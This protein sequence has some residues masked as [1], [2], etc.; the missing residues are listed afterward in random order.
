MIWI[1][2]SAKNNSINRY[3]KEQ[4]TPTGPMY[5][6]ENF[7][8]HFPSESTDLADLTED[9]VNK[10]RNH[11][12]GTPGLYEFILQRRDGL[13]Y[14]EIAKEVN[15]PIG[16]VRSRIH[17]CRKE[18]IKAFTKEEIEYYKEEDFLDRSTEKYSDLSL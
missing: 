14:E 10:I 17:R 2:R 16:T 8:F 9:V 7:Y 18:A 12:S 11:L 1:Y 3:R 5:L 13:T 4:K 6:N 15:I